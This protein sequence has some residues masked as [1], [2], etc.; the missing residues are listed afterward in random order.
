MK[1]EI[2]MFTAQIIYTQMP[3]KVGKYFRFPELL[4]EL[5]KC[6]DYG[7]YGLDLF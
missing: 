6:G 3:W 1:F 2:F 5:Y 4:P 7:T